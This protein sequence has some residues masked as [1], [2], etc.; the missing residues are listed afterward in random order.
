MCKVGKDVEEV[1]EDLEQRDGSYL[2]EIYL[3]SP[4]T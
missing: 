2:I 1:E 3:N 4:D